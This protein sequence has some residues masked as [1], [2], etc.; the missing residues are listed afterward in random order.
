[1]GLPAGLAAPRVSLHLESLCTFPVLRG[2]KGPHMKQGSPGS[3]GTTA[4]PME[5]LGREALISDNSPLEPW[6]CGVSSRRAS[7][8]VCTAPTRAPSN[9]NAA[10][11]H[12]GKPRFCCV[13]SSG[14]ALREKG[15]SKVEL[16]VYNEFVILRFHKNIL[17]CI[18]SKSGHFETKSTLR[19]TLETEF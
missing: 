11:G 5:P 7:L 4:W 6:E 13:S 1:M 17:L 16:V 8:G 3:S 19:M 2:L 9:R 10:R 12:L 14:C 15:I 18:E